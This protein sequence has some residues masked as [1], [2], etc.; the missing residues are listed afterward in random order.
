VLFSITLANKDS[1]QIPI[2]KWLLLILITAVVMFSSQ[3]P[4]SITRGIIVGFSIADCNFK[5]Y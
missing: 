4:S 3:R 2:Y 5:S 1:T